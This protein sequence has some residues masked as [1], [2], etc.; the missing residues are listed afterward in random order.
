MKALS[1]CATWL[2]YFVFYCHAS[3]DVRP[4]VRWLSSFFPSHFMFVVLFSIGVIW[5]AAVIGIG[6]L[7]LVYY[8]R[9][10][11]LEQYR[12]V[13]QPWPWSRADAAKRDDYAS[14]NRKTFFEF[15]VN[16]ISIAIIAPLAFMLVWHSGADDDFYRTFPTP[17]ENCWKLLVGNLIFDTIFYW[18]HRME[19]EIGWMYAHHK[20]HHQY[21][22][23]NALTG[24]HGSHIDSFFGQLLT[25]FVP[26]VG[27]K[28]HLFTF[29]QF[30]VIHIWHSAYD[31]GGYQF[32]YCPLQ[33]I[34][35]SG[36][37]R[38]HAY[39]HTHNVGN[40][41]LYYEFWDSLCGTNA[42]YR[43]HQKTLA[44]SKADGATNDRKPS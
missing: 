4:A 9:H 13:N 15:L 25:T 30:V 18:T 2:T 27:L 26:V 22:E 10:P 21:V 19:H 1:T 16:D 17:W 11:Y 3:V 31:H 23:P 39:H 8:L 38:A 7:F 24:Q 44:L 34:P 35:F 43:K 12:C 41:G 20:R 36:Y 14:L 32:D 37:V 40:Y 5:G 33:L 29:W 6:S 42:A 28:Y